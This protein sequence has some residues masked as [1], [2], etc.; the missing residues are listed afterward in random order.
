MVLLMKLQSAFNQRN[1]NK[2]QHHWV[3]L[4]KDVWKDAV[5]QMP[6]QILK[7]EKKMPDAAWNFMLLL[8]LTPTTCDRCRF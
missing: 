2:R 3:K 6:Q 1:P 7:E 8:Q 4:E 5:T